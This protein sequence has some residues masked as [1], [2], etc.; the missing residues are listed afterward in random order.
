[1][2]EVKF[3]EPYKAHNVNGSI[4]QLRLSE[5]KY[6]PTPNTGRGRPGHLPV[7]T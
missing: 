5:V 3:Q 4:R 1:M 7:F 2:N 6:K